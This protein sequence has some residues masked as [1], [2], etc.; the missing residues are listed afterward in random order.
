[1]P[2]LDSF[3]IS[4][5]TRAAVEDAGKVVKVPAGRTVKVQFDT[6]ETATLADLIGQ[7]CCVAPASLENATSQVAED[8]ALIDGSALE[9]AS[10][11]AIRL[12]QEAKVLE[13][14]DGDS[15]AEVGE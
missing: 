1:M 6:L 4:N 9:V 8:D 2:T 7:G 3:F 10:K 11:G 13:S 14:V 5:A 12:A 15:F